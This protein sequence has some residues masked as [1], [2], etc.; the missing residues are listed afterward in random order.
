M[1]SI[2]LILASSTQ[3][4]LGGVLFWQDSIYLGC[5]DQLLMSVTEGTGCGVMVKGFL[6][7]CLTFHINTCCFM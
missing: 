4:V 7:R 1:L 3:C 5:R 2:E 6:K